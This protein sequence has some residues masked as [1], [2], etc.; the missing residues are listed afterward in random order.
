MEEGRGRKTEE[1]ED[2]KMEEGSGKWEG[3]EEEGEE[4]GQE[5]A[6]VVL[7]KNFTPCKV[8]QIDTA[9]K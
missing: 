7:L 9:T 6:S 4:E 1:K 3:G 5:A 8:A 2:Q